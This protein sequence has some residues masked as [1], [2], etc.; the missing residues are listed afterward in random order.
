MLVTLNL[1]SKAI[2]ATAKATTTAE[3]KAEMAIIKADIDLRKKFHKLETDM[4]VLQTR[5]NTIR[6]GHL[7]GV[8]RHAAQ[9]PALRTKIKKLKEDMKAVK[10]KYHFKTLSVVKL[11]H[12]LAALRDQA[13]ASRKKKEE[14]LPTVKKS[15]GPKPVIV[16]V[17]NDGTQ[18][19][20]RLGAKPNSAPIRAKHRPN[21]AAP[22]AR[23]KP[24]R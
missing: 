5:V 14:K 9:V 7:S 21:A 19:V 1:D 3:R 12:K 17:A 16:H 6:H 20:K 4:L 22:R 23:I 18:S 2:I 8:S 15:N 24:N 13:A 10:A 11:I